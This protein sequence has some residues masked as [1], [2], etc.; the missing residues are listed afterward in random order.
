NHGQNTAVNILYSGTVSA[1]S[2]GYLS[3]V[4]SIAFS[5]ASHDYD[6]D[7]SV[8]QKYARRIVTNLKNSDFGENFLL[9]VNIPYS[10]ER[11]IKGI[12]VVEHSDTVW[13]D[14]YELRKDPF[15]RE[16]YWFAGEYK[17]SN[18]N[19]LTDD[20]ALMDNYVTVT[21][22]QYQLTNFSQLSK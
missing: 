11:E 20:K 17:I 15:N 14:K 5:L 8:A 19:P 2:E 9:N 6:A 3:G 13:K 10:N 12:K 1:A 18:F 22:L 7:F 16:Y 21:P 4:N